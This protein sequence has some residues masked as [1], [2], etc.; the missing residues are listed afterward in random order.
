MDPRKTQRHVVLLLV[1]WH[2]TTQFA[3]QKVTSES[4]ITSRYKLILNVIPLI[5]CYD[6]FL[7]FTIDL[8]DVQMCIPIDDGKIKKRK[9]IYHIIPSK[10]TIKIRVSIYIYILTL[11]DGKIKKRKVIYHIIPST[12]TIKI[13]VGIDMCMY[14]TYWGLFVQAQEHTC[15][16]MVFEYMCVCNID[17]ECGIYLWMY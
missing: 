9:V 16:Y 13:R 6:E 15:L 2:S 8:W 5:N 1:R 3:S 14:R 12:C 4:E 17:F 11:D 10:C 7:L